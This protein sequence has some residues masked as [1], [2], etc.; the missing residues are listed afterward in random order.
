MGRRRRILI[1]VFAVVGVALLCW[2]IGSV[3]LSSPPSY[4]GRTVTEWS[5]DLLSPS[6]ST[7]A[8]ASQALQSIGP[9]A[10]PALSRQLQRRDS[11]LRNPFMAVSSQLPVSWRRAFVR[12]Y[13][14]FRAMDERLAAVNALAL[15]GTNAP[16]DL[17]IATLRDS[18]RQLANQAAVALSRCGPA[19]VPGLA[20]ALRDPNPEVRSLACST[21]S[22]IGRP[23]ASA[24]PELAALLSDPDPQLVALAA[25]ALTTVGPAA[26]PH[27]V[28]AL[29]HPLPMVRE[30]AAF[31][32]GQLGFSA[33]SALPALERSLEDENPGVRKYA[34]AALRAIA[35]RQYQ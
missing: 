5:L 31:A 16:A 3:W 10:L 25:H 13:H 7:R 30:K 28:E 11:W 6:L 27:L 21:L 33:R 26:V 32:L 20:I 17:L 8:K 4:D 9:A 15:F 19:A 14:P 22:Q 18:E 12:F 1:A 23:A 24:A 35:P 34:R 2:M 29:N